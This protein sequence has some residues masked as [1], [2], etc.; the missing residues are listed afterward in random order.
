MTHTSS[1]LCL[2]YARGELDDIDDIY[3]PDEDV[4]EKLAAI[5]RR[6][7]HGGDRNGS[8]P[9]QGGTNLAITTGSSQPGKKAWRGVKAYEDFVKKVMRPSATPG[10]DVWGR[11]SQLNQF[12]GP[13][14]RGRMLFGYEGFRNLSW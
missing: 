11:A 5:K 8:D 6:E 14:G 4:V 7:E 3:K 12:N 10:S 13:V 2:R 1:I 9:K